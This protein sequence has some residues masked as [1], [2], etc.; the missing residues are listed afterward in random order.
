MEAEAAV[1]LLVHKANMPLKG[2]Y[3]D[4]DLCCESKRVFILYYSFHSS[5]YLVIHGGNKARDVRFTRLGPRIC[6]LLRKCTF[7]VD[8]ILCF[9]FFYCN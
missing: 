1:G 6:C 2:V 9:V 7:V 5:D 8:N 4:I 3:E